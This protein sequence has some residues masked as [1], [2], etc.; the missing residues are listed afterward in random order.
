M[1]KPILIAASPNTEEDDLELS[2]RYLFNSS[3]WYDENK[4]KKIEEI[5]SKD[6]SG[7]AFTFDSARSAFYVYLK[8][9]ELPE[10]SEV[11]LPA[12]SCMVIANSVIWAGL[13]PVLVDCNKED[14]NYDFID[15]QKKVTDKTRVVLVQHSFGFPEDLGGVRAIVGEKVLIVEDLAHSLGGFDKNGKKLGSLADASIITF[16]IE[17]VISGVRGGMLIV[18]NNDELAEKIKKTQS[19]LQDFPKK[20]TFIA[21]LNPI[22][23]SII[24]PVYYFGFGKFTLGRLIVYVSH[25]LGVFGIMIE[26]CEYK[27]CKPN[28]LPSKISPVLSELALNQYLKLEMF[29]THR[30]EIANQYILELGLKNVKFNS[31]FLRFPLRVNNRAKV[32]ELTK[33]NGIVLGDW[34]KTILYAPK[35]AL[36]PLGYVLGS[37]PNAETLSKDIINLPTHIKVSKEDA[38]KIAQ[39]IKPFVK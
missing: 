16:G 10:D 30:F 11:I 4:T 35:E 36:G 38:L 19:N 32:I 12:F 14:Y 26:N 6:F 31:V 7:Q 20:K 23:W 3:S 2:K 28:W 1:L 25:L 9:L 24:T 37:C 29:N 33:K 5:F 39:I 18:R 21:L 34:Y 8:S 13:K 17:K 15:L 22:L 27:Q